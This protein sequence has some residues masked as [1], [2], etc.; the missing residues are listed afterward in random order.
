[1][2]EPLRQRTVVCEN[3]QAFALRIQPPNIRPRRVM[4]NAEITAYVISRQNT[5]VDASMGG[6]VY[7]RYGDVGGIE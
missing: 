1:M 5:A 4:K 7:V 2:G 3:E 6:K